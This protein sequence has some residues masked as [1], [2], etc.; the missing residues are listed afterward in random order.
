MGY[1]DIHFHLLPGVDDGARNLDE[2]L[3]M[4]RLAQ[5]DGVSRIIATPHPNYQTGIGG[6][7]VTSRLVEDFN[8]RLIEANITEIKVVPGV[9]CYL[10]PELLERLERQQLFGLNKGRYV[11]IEFPTVTPPLNVEHLMFGLRVKGF[12][13]IIAHP[14]RYQYVQ[15][16]PEWLAKLVRLG[17]LSQLTAG[18][19][20]GRFG[21]RCQKSA[22]ILLKT[23]LCHVIASDAHNVQVRPPGFQRALPEIERLAGSESLKRLLIEVPG[24]ILADIYYEPEPPERSLARPMWKFW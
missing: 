21:K 14:E 7:E 9:E 8:R 5:I 12:I 6:R 18:A 24:R 16:D 11:L 20:W 3:E 1:I 19:F 2:A 22:E 10:E 15:Q 23:N 4:A 17:C 13:P